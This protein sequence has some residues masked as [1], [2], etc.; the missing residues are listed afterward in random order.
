[1][2]VEVED[3]A[4]DH[5]MDDETDPLDVSTFEN[6]KGSM[7]DDRLTGDHRMNTIMGGDGDDTISGGGDF[8]VLMGQGGDDS[9]MGGAGGDHLIGGPG[10]DRLDGGEVRG[11][12]DNMIDNPDAEGKILTTDLDWAVYRPAMAGVEVDLSDGRGTGGDAMGDRLIG[13]EVVWGSK[14]DDTF[15]ASADE[16]TYDIIH[17]DS[18]SDT[19]SYEASEI[20]VEVSLLTH[21][22]NTS[23]T[24]G[25]DG[26]PGNPFTF[27][28]APE[29]D[30]ADINDVAGDDDAGVTEGDAATNGAYLDRLGGIQNL[31]GSNKKDMLTGDGNPNVLKGGGGNDTLVGGGQADRLY[32]GD[33]RDTLNGGDGADTLNGGAGDN[34]E[35]TGGADGDTF[36]FAPGDGY[37]IIND[38]DIT[39]DDM[40][41]L[42][43]FDLDADDLAGMIDIRGG[44]VFITIGDVT[45]ELAGVSDIDTLDASETVDQNDMFDLGVDPDGNVDTG[46]FII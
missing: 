31:T 27:T 4:F 29:D 26:T 30:N 39:E 14:H 33:G 38:L 34:D 35:L 32:G 28:Y 22:D 11:E 20:G 41:D 21:N 25:G 23:V 3:E 12:R 42:T 13:I 9:I 37:G 2:R 5:D 43:A 44:D 24:L 7:H 10:A 8:D 46:V 17:G 18:G 40:I 19:V 45:I 1:M 36:V 6:L 16:D 15:I